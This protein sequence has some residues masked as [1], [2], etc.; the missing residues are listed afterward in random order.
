MGSKNSKDSSK[1]QER[2]YYY[3]STTE[4]RVLIRNIPLGIQALRDKEVFLGLERGDLVAYPLKQNNNL[5]H[6]GVYIGDG[7]I[8]SKYP[9]EGRGVLKRE[10]IIQEE[11][12]FIFV[13]KKGSSSTVEHAERRY[14]KGNAVEGKSH[15]RYDAF[16]YNLM[17][18]NCE[19]F[20]EDCIQGTDRKGECSQ[21][22]IS[23]IFKNKS[24]YV[25]KSD[26]SN[27]F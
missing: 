24:S 16:D 6:I 20:A 17:T 26:D 2:E 8:I 21:S 3:M 13:H 18:S 14:W 19:H 27:S 1:K 15:T 5:I 10:Y 9:E 11:W 7:M 12:D 25:H 4:V 22:H 23:G